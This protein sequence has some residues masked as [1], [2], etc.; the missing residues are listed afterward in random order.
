MMDD[1]QKNAAGDGILDPTRQ[2][3][4]EGVKRHAPSKLRVFLR[5]YSGAANKREAI[6]A[7]CLD[8]SNLTVAEVRDCTATGCPLWR[9]RPYQRKG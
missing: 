3:I 9:Y 2:K 1:P 8:C 5:A 7:K 6:R 4:V